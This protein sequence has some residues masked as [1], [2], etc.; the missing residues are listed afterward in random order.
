MLCG[1]ASYRVKPLRKLTKE[2]AAYAQQKDGVEVC[3]A[4]VY[5]IEFK[6]YTGGTYLDKKAHIIPVLITVNNSTGQLIAWCSK[7]VLLPLLGVHQVT[8]QLRFV[9]D[10][11][12][13]ERGAH[14]AL[15]VAGVLAIFSSVTLLACNRMLPIDMPY[16][17]LFFRFARIVAYGGV[18]GFVCG[19]VYEKIQEAAFEREL[20]LDIAD[21]MLRERELISAGDSLTKLLMTH[22][23]NLKKSF[24]LVV[25]KQDGQDVAFVV[26]V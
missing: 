16:Y 26:T 25:H 14:I 18:I 21:K 24:K 6:G 17:P 7:D 9:Y 10:S 23:D 22:E 13:F 12:A 8:G 11:Y 19:F 2:T 5:P 20:K 4:R 1:C 3:A 15:T